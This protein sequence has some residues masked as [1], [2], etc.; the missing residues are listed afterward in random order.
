MWERTLTIGSAGKTFCTT[1]VKI[2]W[3]IGP[4]EL[5]KLCEAVHNNSINSCPTFF[6]VISKIKILDF[7]NNL[8]LIKE[9]IARCFEIEIG[10]IK[11]PEGI[12]ES[13]KEEIKSKRDHIVELI[14]DAGLEPIMP[15]SLRKHESIFESIKHE[16]K[17]KRDHVVELLIDA[18]LDPIVPGF[19][20]L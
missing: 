18:G 6:Q 4:K 20:L 19:E 12:F 11:K 7:I 16:L 10:A 8:I 17:L 9:A 3:T 14:S 1:G 15:T 13:I 2:G 5:I